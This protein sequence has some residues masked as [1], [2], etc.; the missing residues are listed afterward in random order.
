LKPA[1]N[2]NGR[3]ETVKRFLVDIED[4]LYL[5]LTA[6]GEDIH[7]ILKQALEGIAAQNDAKRTF[8]DEALLTTPDQRIAAAS[9]RRWENG[10]KA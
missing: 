8:R 9:V 7:P 1:K 4:E 5:R 10:G 6:G 2:Q 3:D